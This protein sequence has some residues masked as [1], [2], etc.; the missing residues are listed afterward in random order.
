MV[1]K[2]KV[3]EGVEPIKIG[4]RTFLLEDNMSFVQ[5]MYVM[6]LVNSM[7]LDDVD[8]NRLQGA[9]LHREAKKLVIE[10]YRTGNMFKLLGAMF[11]E[12][13]TNPDEWT[14]AVAD[15][16]G[17]A[18]KMIRD[19]ETKLAIERNMVLILLSFFTTGLSSTETFLNFS[20]DIGVEQPEDSATNGEHSTSET[21]TKLSARS[22]EA[23]RIAEER[24]QGGRSAK[25][26]SPTSK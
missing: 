12:K 7:G 10:S 17:E 20:G 24:L 23:I 3:P 22:R 15:A 25:V 11:T 9:S 5:D 8:V 21:G 4:D 16:N 26:S 19:K 14:E 13:G 6:D 1:K 18:F 2:K